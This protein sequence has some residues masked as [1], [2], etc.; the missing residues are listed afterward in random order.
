VTPEAPQAVPTARVLL[1]TNVVSELVRPRPA[2]AVIAYLD[3]LDP[4]QTYLSLITIGEIERGIAQA[5]LPQRAIKLR[6]WLDGQLLPQYAGRILAL[7]EAVGRRWG[8][9]MALPA[10]R[11]RSGL[12]INALIAA[13]A[14][15]HRLTLVTRHTRDFGVF[16]LATFDP[17][18]YPRL[19]PPETT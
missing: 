10:V 16:P 11:A 19:T 18:T 13:S 3:T 17:W 4:V 5:D 7:D 2:P 6:N 9:L 8:E 14:S 1:D 12:A 15:M